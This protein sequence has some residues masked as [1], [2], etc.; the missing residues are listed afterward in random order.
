MSITVF[1]PDDTYTA[2][3]TVINIMPAVASAT[4]AGATLAE[5]NAGTM[6][7]CAIEEFSMTTDAQTRTRK[8]L[9]DDVAAQAP[10]ARTYQ[11]GDT[12]VVAPD[13]QTANTFLD[14][15]TVGAVKYVSVRP[16]MADDTAAAATQKIW[17]DKRQILSID[18]EPITTED[19]NAYA[20]RIRWLVMGRN[21]KATILA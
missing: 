7:Q 9:C 19:G 16:G 8:K 5:W 6:I 2:R 10:G 17:L 15:L 20:W 3:N 1:D 21:L 14:S 4:L 11:A 12:V 18:P 13:P